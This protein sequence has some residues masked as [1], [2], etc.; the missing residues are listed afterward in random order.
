MSTNTKHNPPHPNPNSNPHP[1]PVA[2]DD[3]ALSS[4]SSLAGDDLDTSVGILGLSTAISN[5]YPLTVEGTF[6]SLVF[7][8]R[9]VNVAAKKCDVDGIE[10]PATTFHRNMISVYTHLNLSSPD[11][12]DDVRFM[13]GKFLV[14]LCIDGL[15]QHLGYR[16]PKTQKTQECK[17]YIDKMVHCVN[18]AMQSLKVFLCD[19]NDIVAEGAASKASV[20]SKAPVVPK[21]PVTPFLTRKAKPSKLSLATSISPTLVPSIPA[22]HKDVSSVGLPILPCMNNKYIA[23]RE[24]PS[25]KFFRNLFKRFRKSVTFP[26]TPSSVTLVLPPISDTSAI[27]DALLPDKPKPLPEIPYENR[28][29]AIYFQDGK[30]SCSVDME[31]LMPTH[32]DSSIRLTSD[33]ALKSASLTSL[34][35]IL[36]SPEA[37]RMPGFTHTFFMCFIFFASPQDLLDGLVARFQVGK[38]W[39]RPDLS[40]EDADAVAAEVLAV[41]VSVVRTLTTWLWEYWRPETDQVL[42]QQIM[43]FA[44]QDIADAVPNLLLVWGLAQAVWNIDDKKHYRGIKMESLLQVPVE[45][46]LPIPTCFCIWNYG[47]NTPTMCKVLETERGREEFVRQITIKASKMFAAINPSD[48]IRYWEAG[49]RGFD[50]VR[51]QIETFK[52]FE[53]GVTAAVVASILESEKVVDRTIMLEYWLDVASRCVTW[54]NYCVANCISSAVQTSSVLRLKTTIALASEESKQK[55]IDLVALFDGAAN[56]ASHR[57]AIAAEKKPAVPPMFHFEHD[58]SAIRGISTTTVDGDG[59]KT[60]LI[61]FIPVRNI[62]KVLASME[63]YRIDYCL[64]FDGDFQDWLKGSIDTLQVTQKKEKELLETHYALS[65]SRESACLRLQQKHVDVWSHPI[66]YYWADYPG[67]FPTKRAAPSARFSHSSPSKR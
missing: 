49:K 37:D 43:D 23:H 14:R 5:T 4:S 42:L 59:R 46:T 7:P 66:T 52:T 63:E 24:T 18:S 17:E 50:R 58:V 61:N 38:K 45:R 20:V 21:G 32:D 10:G 55:Y 44:S 40:K 54:R 65:K 62:M 47:D 26:F 12:R 13:L 60:V 34:I 36:T 57:A 67:P 19:L 15:K 39:Q 51:R 31:R 56:F 30:H 41:R 33:G 2:N 3:A 16:L 1:K 28:R 11:I 29:S 27:K 64:D 6:P 9:L 8:H 53:R 22:R 35:R 25:S 48:A